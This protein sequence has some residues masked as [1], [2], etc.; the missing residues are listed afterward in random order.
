MT[1]TTL[2]ELLAEAEGP[3]RLV[4][5]KSMSVDMESGNTRMV[6]TVHMYAEPDN[7]RRKA[8]SLGPVLVG[9]SYTELLT[10]IA[11]VLDKETP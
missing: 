7:P 2:E 8:Q 11:S 5:G 4:V 3:I 9:D 6:H 1:V 10:T